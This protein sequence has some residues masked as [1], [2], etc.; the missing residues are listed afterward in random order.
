MRT[1]HSV[2]A[3][4]DILKAW[5]PF[6]KLV[7][8]TRVR[9]KADHAKASAIIAVLLDEVGDDEAHPLAEVLDYLADKVG[10]WEA[11][12]VDIP[13]ADPA[14]VLRFL[15]GQ[16]GLR[17]EDLAD[18]APQGRISDYL[19]GRRAISKAAAKLLAARF[20]VRAD[21]FL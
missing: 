6:K 12:N 15:M 16:H 21:I 7:G 13:E 19:A 2:P 4:K 10:E 3:V 1:Q 18:C 17:Q 14:E 9:T 8:V 20:N 11:E 5:Q